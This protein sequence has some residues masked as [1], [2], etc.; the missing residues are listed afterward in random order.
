M[1]L[2]LLLI[3]MASATTLAAP[4]TFV[5]VYT[6]AAEVLQWSDVSGQLTGTRQLVY[7]EGNPPVFKTQN[8][9]F[10]G[11][12]SG[13]TI[14]LKFTS[15]F[16]GYTDTRILLGTLAGNNLTLA[17]P[18]S[19][20]GISSVMYTKSSSE[21]YN[22][23]VQRLYTQVLT[24]RTALAQAEQK[25]A[26]QQ[27]KINA[28]TRIISDADQAG[29]RAIENA[30]SLA[31]DLTDSAKDLQSTAQG[32]LKDLERLQK[33]QKNSSGMQRTQRI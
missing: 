7:R 4:V 26:A 16:L 33:D 12:R 21:A 24:E 32:F 2:S 9:T 1:R 15:S 8:A 14:S 22:Q 13:N 29:H 23:A 11:T 17:Q 20:G 28:Q 25:R 27:A 3:A 31:S 6:D 5:K 10:T 30:Q 19:G 18:S